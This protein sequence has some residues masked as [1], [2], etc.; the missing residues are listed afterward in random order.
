LGVDAVELDVGLTTDGVVIVNHDQVLSPLT[1]CDTEPTWPG[2]AQFP[3][4]GRRLRELTLDQI[5]T[6]DA[7]VRQARADGWPSD[8]DPL[9]LTQL[10]IPGTTLP[11]LAEVCE[12]LDGY[13]SRHIHLA[14][15]L[16]TD[17]SWSPGDVEHFVTAVADVLEACGMSRRSRL[18]AFDWRVL[19][20][21]RRAAPRLRRVAL[22][23]Q[24]TL[25]DTD[26]AGAPWLAGLDPSDWVAAA[27]AI[28][29]DVLS[30][31]HSLITSELVHDAHSLNL[32]VAV[33]TVNDTADMARFIEYGVDAI[34]TDYPDRLRRV[35]ESQGK[36]LPRPAR[37][38]KPAS[39]P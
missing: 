17:P 2:D 22:V 15:E 39:T 31:E 35:M 12:L 7:G 32:P 34:V 8:T 10:P 9:V 27:A 21:A 28:G 33:W 1:C 11:T 25:I 24:K 36:T 13:D 4:V 23:G 18:L 38:R 20:A 14:V 6:V 3:Y 16:K 29:A 19:T 5:K 30:P 26:G 37:P